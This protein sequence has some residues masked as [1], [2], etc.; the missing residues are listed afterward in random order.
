MYGIFANI[1]L[2]CMA[3]VGKYTI[4]GSYGLYFVGSWPIFRFELVVSGNVYLG[5]S[6]IHTSF[7]SL[8]E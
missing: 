2:I 3:N 6:V 7:L 4:H 5:F 1:W 8:G